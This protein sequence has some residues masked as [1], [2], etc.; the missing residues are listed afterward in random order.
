MPGHRALVTMRI[1]QAQEVTEGEAMPQREDEGMRTKVKA[2]S[3]TLSRDC[4]LRAYYN[5]TA[6]STISRA[7]LNPSSAN[8]CVPPFNLT[9]LPFTFLPSISTLK[10]ST[11]NPLSVLTAISYDSRGQRVM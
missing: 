1:R 5:T 4:I 9:V 10:S 6:P 11:D 3:L 7:Y 2:R 8:T